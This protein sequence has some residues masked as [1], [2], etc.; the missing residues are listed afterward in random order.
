M[1]KLKNC[2]FCAGEVEWCRCGWLPGDGCHNIICNRC[3]TF[4]MSAT[5]T[6]ATLKKLKKY[7]AKKW[8]TRAE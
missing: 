2:P 7:C 6:P 8:N 1:K 5:Y 3:G 4:D